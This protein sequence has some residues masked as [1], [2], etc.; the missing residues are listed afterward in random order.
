MKLEDEGAAEELGI[1][2]LAGDPYVI[3]DIGMRMFTPR[4]LIRTQGFPD[5]Y[6]FE[7]ELNGRVISKSAQVSAFGNAVPP[8]FAKA[9]VE[10]NL[11][12]LCQSMDDWVATQQIGDDADLTNG[13]DVDALV[14]ALSRSEEQ[15]DWIDPELDQDV[16]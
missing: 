6:A 10:A 14:A 5:E 15:G 13:D 3:V 11:P 16:L 8:V 7:V 1:V 2:E 9:L 12:E 4:E